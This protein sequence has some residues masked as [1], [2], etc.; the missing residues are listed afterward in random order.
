MSIF[1]IE[2]FLADDDSLQTYPFGGLSSFLPSLPFLP[3][4]LPFSLLP[5][6]SP[7]LLSS[8]SFSLSP[9]LPYFSSLVSDPH[10]SLK[11]VPIYSHSF[12]LFSSQ[13]LYSTYLLCV[14]FHLG[15]YFSEVINQCTQLWLLSG[16]CN[17]QWNVKRGVQHTLS[18]SWRSQ[19]LLF[20]CLYPPKACSGA[21][22]KEGRGQRPV[23][24]RSKVVASRQ[25]KGITQLLFFWDKLNIHRVYM[26]CF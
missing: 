23:M 7:F 11:I 9:S 17:K 18:Y 1:Y 19:E 15:A 12:F 10:Y 16:W 14:W 21:N 13:V 20:L 25:G 4:S 6:P 24:E 8:L 3:S 2:N 22:L 26:L 5:F